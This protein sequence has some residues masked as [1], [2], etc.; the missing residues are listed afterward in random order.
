MA[1]G[2]FEIQSYDVVIYPDGT[3]NNY[4]CGDVSPEKKA[5]IEAQMKAEDEEKAK[6]K[7]RY[8]ELSKEAAEKR[9]LEME[10]TYKRQNMTELLA[11]QAVDTSRVTYTATPEVMASVA[12][13]YENNIMG[14]TGILQ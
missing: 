3:A 10:L 5:K 1:T 13:A 12:A 9:K 2:G 11:K 4:V 8:Q 7:R 6:R 14:A